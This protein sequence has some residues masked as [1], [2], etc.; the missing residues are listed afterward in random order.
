MKVLITGSEGIIGRALCPMLEERGHKV[1]RF[2]LA[3]APS[4]D[5]MH[6]MAVSAAQVLARCEAII[7]LA[8]QSGVNHARNHPYEA[9]NLNVIGT[10]NVLETA[11]DR[12][13]PVIV[14]SSNHVYGAQMGRTDEDAPLLNL[15]TYSASKIAADV[16]ARSY[17]NDFGLKVAVV[18]NTNCYSPNTPPW[19][20]HLIEETIRATMR[21]EIMVLRSDGQTVK[22]YLHVEDVA[23]AY[24]TLLETG[25][26][27][28]YNVTSH[29]PI[30]AD[31]LVLCITTMMGRAEL[32]LVVGVGDTWQHDEDLDDAK[33]RQLGW[34][35]RYSLTDGLR[36][37]IDAM[38][39]TARV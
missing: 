8:A 7:H 3:G 13:I 22:S 11:R 32:G 17:A 20:E 2:D 36:A 21:G 4:D 23:S 18:R 9:W 19:H 5:V 34:E 14:A 10:L 30:R 29:E 25:A 38:T 33:I 28:A 15:D 35:P 31:D 24:V 12:D 39:E 26:T 37:T 6:L 16:M 1:T 27:G